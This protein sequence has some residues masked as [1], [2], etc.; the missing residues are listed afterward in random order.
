M[1]SSRRTS[2]RAANS[3]ARGWDCRSRTSWR[4]CWEATSRCRATPG[5]AAF[6]LCTCRWCASREAPRSLSSRPARRSDA[7]LADQLVL[8][9][10]L[11]ELCIVRQAELAQDARAVGADRTRAEKHLLRDLADRLAGSEQ[12]EHAVFAIGQRLVRRACPVRR[13]AGSQFLRQPGADV[14]A[15]L[16][17]L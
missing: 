11:D 8:D 15:A 10:V 1:R 7:R 5:T 17:D 6:S 9:G 14:A 2:S 13:Q 16:G 4:C 3:A 12:P